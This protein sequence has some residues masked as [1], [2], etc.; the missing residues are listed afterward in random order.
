MV[1]K[2][3]KNRNINFKIIPHGN[4]DFFFKSHSIHKNINEYSF[5]NPFKILYVSSIEHYKNHLKLIDSIIRLRKK[6][7]PITLDLVGSG[8][9]YIENSIK[10]KLKI[11]NNKEFIFFNGNKNPKQLREFYH[12]S[13]LF[14]YSSSC[15]TF[16]QILLESMS[17][18]LPILCSSMTGLEETAKDAAIYFD[19]LNDD[20]ID[21]KLKKII[22]NTS[23]REEISK[24]AFNYAKN[25]SWSVCSLETFNFIEKTYNKFSS[26]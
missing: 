17:S 18:R 3:I 2:K 22:D 10:N 25:Y 16:G 15:E 7:Y 6:N 23:L 26:K 14:V 20:D 13:N 4:D 11:E 1:L 24:K 9:K 21:N 19:P 5:K 12:G 8:R